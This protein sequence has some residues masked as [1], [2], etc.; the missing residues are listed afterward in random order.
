MN[1]I[2]TLLRPQ[3]RGTEERRE[4]LEVFRE[5]IACLDRAARR[6]GR[7]APKPKERG[8]K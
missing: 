8:N 3:Q 2:Q 6:R 5:F 4:P 7:K 1:S